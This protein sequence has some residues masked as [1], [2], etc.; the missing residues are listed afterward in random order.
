MTKTLFKI[1]LTLLLLCSIFF[2]LNMAKIES[3][4]ASSYTFVPNYNPN[5]L[6]DN[7]TFLDNATMTASDIQTFLQNVGSGL[8]TYTTTETCSAASTPYY[9]HCGQVISAAQAIYD[10]SQA[11]SINPRDIIATMQKEQSLITDPTPTSS[12][13]NCAMGY[14]SCTAY[15]GFFSQVDNAT[16]QFRANIDLAQGISFW[17]YS[18]S[19]YL[20]SQPSPSFYSAGLYP[21]N[22]VTFYDQGGTPETITIANAATATLYC[23]TPYVGPYSL[24]GYSGSYNFVYYFQL[25]FGTTL[26]STPYEWVYEGSQV[27]SN[28]SCSYPLTGTATA[29]PG[30][31]FYVTLTGRNVGTNT[32]QQ[33]SMQVGTSNPDNRTS[34]FSNNTWISPT[35]PANMSQS[36][37]SPGTNAS[38][39]F[40]LTAP[41]TPGTYDE[42]FNLVNSNTTWLN[43]PGFNITINVVKPVKPT[44]YNNTTLD[45][46]QTLY[47]SQYLLSPDTDSVLTLQNNGDLIL[48]GGGQAQ[49]SNGINTA[50]GDY[51]T[52]QADGNLVEYSAQNTPLWQTSTNGDTGDYLTLQTDGNLV[53]FSATGTPLWQT[54]TTANPNYLDRVINTLTTGSKLFSMGQSLQPVTRNYS[55]VFQSNGNLVE[56]N[57]QGTAI[58]QTN[59]SGNAGDYLT[60]Q[61]DGNLVMFSSAGT[62]I[63][64]TSTT[65]NAGDYLTLQSNGN[66]V[67]YNAQGSPI[68]TNNATTDGFGLLPGIT[69][70]DGQSLNTPSYSLVLQSDGNLVEFNAQGAPVWQTSTNGNTGD[71]LTLQTDGNLVIF[72]ATGTPIWQ[73]N[74]SGNAG[75]YIS[76]QLNG[77]LVEYNAQGAPVWTN[78]AATYGFNLTSGFTMQIGQ[79]L[80]TPYYSL[81]LE[82]NGNLVEYNAQGAPVWQT[83]TSGNAGSYLTLQSNGNLV[84]FNAQGAPVWTN[85]AA[86]YGFNLTSGFTMQIGQSLKTPYYS[87]VLE[88]NG[89]L[90]EYNA[91]GSPIWQTNTS[92]NAGDYLTLQSNGNLVINSSGGSP[93]WQTNTSGNAGDY[94]TL[95]SNGNLVEYNAQGFPVWSNYTTVN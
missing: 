31:N 88:T 61:A 6:I 14:A 49:W 32:W 62:P 50:P 1:F 22:T 16:W 25:W 39:E 75:D 36:S 42:Y 18:P 17:G 7:G 95:Q 76:L 15:V 93:I 51:L 90:V 19:Q 73:T 46:G 43:D 27:C 44:N 66:L 65:N 87:L 34:Q 68:W 9:S 5:D 70:Q 30:S 55:V 2:V 12:Q 81:V 71:Y 47:G 45:P 79:S 28:P 13:L 85:D 92:G 40:M 37:A 23:Y 74:T 83:S 84:E 35:R 29:S 72:S 89:N 82:T 8:A 38:F 77:N 64:Q 67:E 53:I 94:L 21:G 11:Y 58:W 57:A 10:A 60:L 78:D 69:I 3:A 48:Y 63:W 4:K 52:L 26:A 86:T 54:G 80:K 59:T 24:T 91:Q 41:Y 56:Y 33:S 20:C